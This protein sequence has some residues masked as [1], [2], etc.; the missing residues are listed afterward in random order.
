MW[1]NIRTWFILFPSF[2]KHVSVLENSV[3]TWSKTMWGKHKT[4]QD[5]FV[6]LFCFLIYHMK[7][8]IA[9]VN[10]LALTYFEGI[11]KL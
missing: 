4:G 7:S 10:K 8:I 3:L 9:H 1:S 5:I 6:S 11:F 2:Y